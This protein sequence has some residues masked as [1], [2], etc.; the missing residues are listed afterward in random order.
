MFGMPSVATK[1][2]SGGLITR[3]SSK[4]KKKYH[5]GRGTYEVVVGSAFGPSSAPRISDMK[6]I[7]IRTMQAI[8]ES[9]P[10]AYGKNGLPLAFSALYSRRYCS[11]WR[12]SI[13]RSDPLLVGHGLGLHPRRCRGAEL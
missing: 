11:F 5:S 3:S 6:M 1:T 7:T 4:R 13:E 10:T 2:S 8:S 9:L 12:A